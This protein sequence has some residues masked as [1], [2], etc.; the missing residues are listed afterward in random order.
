VSKSRRSSTE[1][2]T[3]AGRLKARLRDRDRDT[4][5]PK[6]E[7]TYREF[8]ERCAARNELVSALRRAA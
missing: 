6:G 5:L 3:D 4:L 2:L 7:F 1:K 8:R